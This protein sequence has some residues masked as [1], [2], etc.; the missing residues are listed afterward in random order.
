MVYA[1][2]IIF[3][4][5]SIKMRL[6]FLAFLAV[7]VA[8]SAGA[9]EYQP[10][11]SLRPRP[12][13]PGLES[14]EMPPPLPVSLFDGPASPDQRDAWLGS[15]KAW[16]DV[17]K[18][19]IGYKDDLYSHGA[20]DWARHVFTQAQ[21]LVWDRSLYDPV[22]GK[23]TV[24]RA[25]AGLT[26]RFGPIDSVLIWP[27]YPNLGLDARNQFDLMR[28]V[29]GG[30]AGLRALVA[31][32]HRHGIRVFLPVLVW[33]QGT[34]DA[35]VSRAREAAGLLNDVGADGINFDTLAAVPDEA[36]DLNQTAKPPL[37][38]E[39]QFDPQN[40]SLSASAINW[41]DW[42]LWDDQPAPFVP[43]VSKVKWLEPRHMV[44]VTDRYPHFK[45][46]S[47]QHAF[48]N[49]QG[50]AILENL[51]GF[52][53]GFSARDA[54]AVRR[55]TRIERAYADLLASPDWE[56]HAPARRLRQ[57]LPE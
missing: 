50:V 55:F 6:N 14:I 46:N 47:L 18:K 57:P 10:D 48:F 4:V 33:D 3:I 49:G 44:E 34:R 5:G 22:A 2:E 35:G 25:L 24:D 23:Y 9:Q 8:V 27:A 56:P 16:R 54:E 51:W 15:L 11:Y 13:V 20:L 21:I 41:D 36:R 19:E 31:D 28:D 1:G 45:I 52:W 12:D 37:A 30:L 53:N 32:F 42:V 29:P 26:G 38:L 39:P 7:A 17:R 43:R 40:A